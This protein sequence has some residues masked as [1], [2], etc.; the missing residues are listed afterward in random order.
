VVGKLSGKWYAILMVALSM[1]AVLL[2]LMLPGVADAQKKKPNASE[3][4]TTANNDNEVSTA[5]KKKK[6]AAE[7][8]RGKGTVSTGEG[9][10]SFSFNV[11][12]K[13]K[14]P[15]TDKASGTF[16][17]KQGRLFVEGKLSCLVTATNSGNIA[18]FAGKV[19]KSNAPEV[20][21]RS[22]ASFD[23][24]DASSGDALSADFDVASASCHA[25]TGGRLPLT[26]GNIVI[27]PLPLVM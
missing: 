13:D 23:A 27:R 16:K 2:V 18:N 15:A 1:V 19:T 7:F 24:T 3:E 6:K 5:A 11:V 17:L 12:G 4:T 25:P 14:N 10:V 21:A 26:S 8:A 20:P 9:S 22:F